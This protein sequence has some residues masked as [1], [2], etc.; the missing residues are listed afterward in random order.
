MSIRDNGVG[1]DLASHEPGYGLRG[2]RERISA[3]GG[4]LR[5]TSGQG[6]CLTV[7]L[8]TVSPAEGQ[9]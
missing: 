6:A 2:M 9:N 8:P 4:S 1:I 5:L 3:L 7:I